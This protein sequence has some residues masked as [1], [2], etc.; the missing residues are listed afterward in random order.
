VCH[1]FFTYL[2]YSTAAWQI[3]YTMHVYQSFY[4]YHLCWLAGVAVHGFHSNTATGKCKKACAAR[5]IVFQRGHFTV[6]YG[7]NSWIQLTQNRVENV[8]PTHERVVVKAAVFIKDLISSSS[9][10]QTKNKGPSG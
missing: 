3:H 5:Y 8:T 2:F 10:A 1:S 9:V 6:H 4:I 7:I